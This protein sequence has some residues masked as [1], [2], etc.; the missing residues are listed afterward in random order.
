MNDMHQMLELMDRPAFLVEDGIVTAANSPALARGIQ[1]GTR[2]IALRTPD[3]SPDGTRVTLTNGSDA[4]V[5]VLEKGRLY[6][7]EPEETEDGLRQLA[8]AA[9]ALRD[10]LN[11]AMALTDRLEDDAAPA[12][13]RELYRILRVVGNMTPPMTPRLELQDVNE[14]LWELC[15]K[16]LPACESRGMELRYAGPPVPVYSRIDSQLLTRAIHNLLSNSLKYAP[17]GS[18]LRLELKVRGKN[19]TILY[20]DQSDAALPLPDPLSRNLW[21]LGLGGG[22]EG[23]GMGLRLVDQAVK[24]HGG[25]LTMTV[26]EGGGLLAAMHMPILQKPVMRSPRLQ[27]SYTGELDPLLV[28][29]SDVLPADF[30][31]K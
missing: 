12:L 28:E 26:P 13:R 5:T 23:L 15:D 8:L 29:L 19:Y 4:A 18:K 31:Q 2:E 9:H 1:P 24:A 6:T 27:L 10:P 11:N 3:A 20:A 16:A 22:S 14:V 25:I 7:M 21:E 17:A 30:Y